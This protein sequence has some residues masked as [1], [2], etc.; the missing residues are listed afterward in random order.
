MAIP[1]YGLIITAFLLAIAILET[2][3]FSRQ[4]LPEPIEEEEYFLP[5][6][7]EK[8]SAQTGQWNYIVEVVLNVS[9]VQTFELIR[10]ALNASRLPIRLDNSTEISDVSITT[11]CSPTE[12]GVQCR[13]EEQFAWPHSSC[14]TNGCDDIIGGICSCTNVIPADGQFC[15]LISEL[16][17]PVEYVVDVE[18]NVTDIAT[19]DFLRN[20]LGNGDFTLTLGPTVN[21]THINITT[22]CNSNGTHF[23]CRC[24][25]QY[26]W[27]ASNCLT[28]GACDRIFGGTC[29]CIN[30]IPTNG[31]Y[32]EPRTAL[33]EYIISVEV[34]I[35][36]SE[37]LGLLRT[38]LRNINYPITINNNIK[39]TDVNI[40]TVCHS[41]NGSYQC[42]CED[43]YRWPCNQCLTHGSCDNITDN[44]CGCINAISPDGQYC[45]PANQHNFTACPLITTSPPPSTTPPVLYEYI[46]SV[47]LNTTDVTL[48]NILRNTLRNINYPITINN[49]IQIN[50]VNISTVCIPNNGGHQCRCED[51][52]RWPCNQCLTHGSCDNITD[53]TCGCIIAVPPDGQYCQPA[54]QHNF[55]ACP[56]ITTSPPPST[57]PPVLYEYIISVELNTTDVRLIDILRNTLRNINYPITINNNIQINDVNI[58]TVCIPNNGGHQC[59]CEDQYRWPC[60]QCLTHGSCDNITDNTCGCINA[61]PPD[62][63]YCQ[64]ANQHNFTACPLITTS[65]PPSTTPPVLYEYIISV[66]LNTTDVT[67]ID[68]L[69]TTLRNINYPIT[70]NNNIQINDVNISTVCIPNNG[71][72]QCRCEDQY[73]WPCNQCLTH[74]SCDN[75]TDNTCGCINAVPPDGQYCQPANQHNFT[76]CPLITTSPPPS[77]TPP[78]LYEYIISVELN[79]TDVTLIDILRTTL[80]NINYPITIN[81]NIQINDVNISTVCIPNN[82]G[83]QCRCEDQYRWPCNQC[84]THGSC[85]NITDNTC[86]CIN[87]VPP[88]G[89]YCQPANQH[90]FTACPLT[91]TSPPSTN[92]TTT[93]T[94]PVNSTTPT[95]PP[96]NSTTVTTT[97]GNTTLTPTTVTNS[98]T[99]PNTTTVTTTPTTIV[100]NSTPN[101]TTPTA[102][103]TPHVTNTTT[104]T[105][106]P[107]TVVTNSTPN[108]TTPTATPT[109][110]VT[111]TTTV[112]TTPTTVVTNSTPNVTTP[113][114][115]PTPNVTNT[116]TVTTTPT[117]VVTNSTPNVPTP[118]T[119]PT[120]N[121]TT[122]SVTSPNNTGNS[123]SG[124]TSAPTPITTL[125]AVTSTTTTTISTTTDST[126]ATSTLSTTTTPTT[127][128]ATTTTL[129][130]T[131]AP[132]FNVEMFVELNQTFTEDLND[133]LSVKYKELESRIKPLLNEEYKK[134][135]GFM[136][137]SVTGFRKGSIITDFVVRTTKVN[138]VEVA[139]ANEN[140]I[141]AIVDIAPVIGAVTAFYNSPDQMIISSDIIY[142]GNTM[143]LI[144]GPPDNLDVGNFSAS[145]WKFK[146]RKITSGRIE[147]TNSAVNSMLKVNNVILLDIGRY[148]CGL[149][150]GVITFNQK[151]DVT[152]EIK[153]A[154]IIR[155]KEQVNIKCLGTEGKTELLKCCVQSPYKVKWF[156]GSK[157]L[158]TADPTNDG[159]ITYVYQLRSC[160]ELQ[161]IVFT[162]KVDDLDFRKETA[163]TLFTDDII[164]DDDTYG[165]GREGDISR[166]GC[167]IGL[168]GSKTAECQIRSGSGEWTFLRDTCIV[169]EIKELLISSED[170]V[171]EEVSD[172]VGN[173]S[174]TVKANATSITK[175]SETISAI[176]D[177]LNNI[178]AVSNVNVT[179]SVMMDILE[180]VDVIIGD[181]ARES[182]ALLNANE[183][184]NTSSELLGA[185][186]SLANGLVGEFSFTTQRI[187]LNRTTFNDSFKA[188][189]N[190][191]IIIYIPDTDLVNVF[192]TTITFSTLHNVM[193][194]RNSN[195]DAGL[196]N[197]TS[198]NTAIDNAINAAVVLVQI[199]ETID[200]VTLSYD[201]L[202][203]SLTLNPQ[204]VFWNFALFDNLGAWD[205][206]GCTFVSDINNTVTCSCNHLTSFSI[207][208]ATD[209]PQDLREALDIITYVGV[210]ISLASLVICLIIEGYVW[211]A[212]TRNSTAFMRH[213]SIINTALSLLIADICFII[214]ASIAKNPLENPGEDHQVEVGPCS[215]ATFFMHFFYLALFFW[216]LVSG[217]LLF[218]RTVMVFSHMSKS[219][220]LAI[221]F[222]LGYGCPLIIAVITVAVTAPDKGYIRKDN[223]CWLNWFET[224]ALLALVIPA[225]TIVFIN[226]LIVVVVLFKM[227]RRG[228]GDAAQTDERHTVMVL[229]RCVVILTPLFGLT[230]SLG[231]G[232]M[233]SSTNKG[234]H[235]AFAFFNSLQGF[236]ILVFG[237]LFDSKIRSLLS[238]NL[239]TSST[240]SNNQTRSTSGGISSLSGLN[241]INRLRGRRYVYRMSEAA[242]SSSNGASES[243]MNI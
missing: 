46:I 194:V 51:Q 205:D 63:Q 132:G 124:V 170:L 11:V 197:D 138:P 228:V 164:C 190:N 171:K 87:A 76:A 58:S 41:N 135:T 186:E 212:I 180:T 2:G 134:I 1:K 174:V 74:G 143:T 61:V 59:R 56:L 177:I 53:N 172:F 192:I 10:S 214:A 88:D 112:T 38:T 91:T 234:L 201:K 22:V 169:T 142:T 230:W 141:K 44:T 18:L 72:H 202:N 148:E 196:F 239:P 109:P 206:E 125:T 187:L 215:T 118:T 23:Q 86:G 181:D 90:N 8:R 219:I 75:I 184:R 133:A 39:I 144:C 104:V 17:T 93:P 203:E 213:V 6:T 45:Q 32:C 106:T 34:N 33:Y 119:T 117:T 218:Y 29:G 140:I 167:D 227:L 145:E 200:N 30:S 12:V 235:I 116:T 7:R 198:N 108:V 166:I 221:G 173:L 231:V 9:N 110:N 102:T 147:V 3:N 42:R 31:Q 70:I 28:Y 162:C 183:T 139:Q 207:L 240:G 204:C 195:S 155:L 52:Y 49:N 179:E 21:L 216:M 188:D 40:S 217:L 161:P 151:R 129:P 24:E 223:A 47:E 122:T 35:T 193:P 211:K 176:V 84:L 157:E 20:V 182:W 165:A 237:T 26:V 146:G 4:V 100:T 222:L 48:I 25:D 16:L 226:L 68:I 13:C 81:N 80:R 27:S 121:V 131:T 154:P 92:S 97:G 66:E 69:R 36:H 98:T 220:M 50:D 136:S 19:V 126:T 115:T 150:G 14:V 137:V 241:W 149:T 43:Q 5:H 65:P 199:S 236:F 67:L 105:T 114:A 156:N 113:T 55:T 120:P 96:T 85:D 243:F 178:A 37:L 54:N 95:M 71:G 103:P 107:T 57:T 225:L 111:N 238:R 83:H 128:S 159:C 191:S 94:P 208:M 189:L 82:G 78:V 175:S 209:I 210:G 232:T 130:S 233:I 73:R 123:T 185:L 229:I 158:P 127:T 101:V 153:P 77:T 79:T 160:S 242:N 152:N 224:K 62:G 89:Q 64:P 99:D 15:Q 168:E 60:N 163:I